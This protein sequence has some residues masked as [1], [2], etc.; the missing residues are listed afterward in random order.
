MT[1]WAE[2]CRRVEDRASGRCE[3]CKMHQSLQGATFHV[4]HIVPTSAGGSDEEENLAWACPG[5]NL[6]K[7]IRQSAI[8]PQS[9]ATVPLFNPRVDH[10]EE[11]FRC[12]S[13]RVVGITGVGRAVVAALDFNHPRRLLIRQAEEHFG[14]F[15]PSP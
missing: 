5:C 1:S 14:L 11:H 3:Y 2:T 8:D 4:E 13:Y 12:V 7:S 15:P 10:W 9:G 6:H